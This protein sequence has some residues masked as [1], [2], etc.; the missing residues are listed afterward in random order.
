M[1]F[2]KEWHVL[3]KMPKNATY[4]QRLLWHLE[5][6]QNCQCREMSHNIRQELVKRDLLTA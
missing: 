3:H 4:E 1:A 5:H 2:N 6:S